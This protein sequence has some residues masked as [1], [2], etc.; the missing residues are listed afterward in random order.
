[1]GRVKGG[2]TQ[3]DPTEAFQ[4]KDDLLDVVHVVQDHRRSTMHALGE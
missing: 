2:G 4:R 3:N 1:M